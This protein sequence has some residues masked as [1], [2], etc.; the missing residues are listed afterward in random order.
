MKF[1]IPFTQ[2]K[3]EITLDGNDLAQACNRV[4]ELTKEATASGSIVQ[5]ILGVD[6]QGFGFVL[7]YSP[8]ALVVERLAEGKGKGFGAVDLEAIRDL[9]KKRKKIDVFM[10]DSSLLIESGSFQSKLPVSTPQPDTVP[11][12][13]SI[14]M[15][16]ATGTAALPKQML[17]CLTEGTKL[18]ELKDVYKLERTLVTHLVCEKKTPLRVMSYDQTHAAIYTSDVKGDREFRVA[19]PTKLFQI[20]SKFTSSSEAD[21][22][23]FVDESGLR[24]ES[25]NY[26]LVLPPVQVNR[27]EVTA[28][29][30]FEETLRTWA[31]FTIT[32]SL[33]ESIKASLSLTD[34]KGGSTFEMKLSAK[35]KGKIRIRMIS[36]RGETEE[37]HGLNGKFEVVEGNDEVLVKMDPRLLQDIMK[38]VKGETKIKICGRASNPPS[39]ILFNS[40]ENNLLCWGVLV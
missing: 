33:V 18:S 15:G 40:I 37:S 3:F 4:L 17:A 34:P 6:E 10:T 7:G 2:G 38:K 11:Y 19:M 16:T 29:L 25:E 5:H 26:L 27:N 28:T 21:T 9:A 1:Q 20:V 8:E 14:V 39:L 32:D 13:S 36:S 31:E 30:N 12:V 23:F 35:K 24:V 22:N